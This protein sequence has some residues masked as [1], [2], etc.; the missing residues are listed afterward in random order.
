M[1]SSAGRTSERTRQKTCNRK[2]KESQA[3]HVERVDGKECK[4]K[5]DNT[6]AGRKRGM[7][8]DDN[9]MR[10][11]Y[12]HTIELLTDVGSVVKHKTPSPFGVHT[13]ST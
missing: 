13:K 12:L 5:E 3:S 10:A 2:K 4:R 8:V 11:I 9:R 1:F 7:Q 6:M